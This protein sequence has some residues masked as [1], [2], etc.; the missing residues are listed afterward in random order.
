MNGSVFII[1]TVVN[2]MSNWFPINLCN[3]HQV[4]SIS[5]ISA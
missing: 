2:I 4:C 5:N 1:G 3:C